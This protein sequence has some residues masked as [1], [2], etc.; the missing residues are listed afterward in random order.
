M[1]AVFKHIPN[2]F[3]ENVG[4]VAGIVGVIGGV[5]GFIFPIL[6]GSLLS[7]TG[8]WTSCWMVLFAVALACNLWMRSVH[9]RMLREQAPQ[10]A[11][12][13]ESR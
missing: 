12:E 2:Y 13:Y 6:W 4:V 5:G 10:L 3:P 8:V 11:R 9:Q 7:I 1:A